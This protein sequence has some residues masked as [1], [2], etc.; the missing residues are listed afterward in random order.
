[1]R[2]SIRTLAK[3]EP[4]F[5]TYNMLQRLQNRFPNYTFTTTQLVK[6]LV[7]GEFLDMTMDEAL[8]LGFE[9]KGDVYIEYNIDNVEIASHL[10]L[11]IQEAEYGLIEMEHNLPEE[12]IIKLMGSM[13]ES[14]ILEKMKKIN[15]PTV[16]MELF[17]SESK[18]IFIIGSVRP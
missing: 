1:M 6:I 12:E 15:G 10:V 11:S 17:D 7:L 16:D 2:N 13:S 4:I 9:E 8:R 14:E 18:G 5:L 3:N